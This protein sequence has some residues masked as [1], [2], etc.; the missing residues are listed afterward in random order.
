MTPK[1][2]SWGNFFTAIVLPPEMPKEY[3]DIEDNRGRR[4]V[5]DEKV[6]QSFCRDC[7]VYVPPGR[8][9]FVE[10][11]VGQVVLCRTCFEKRRRL[12]ELGI[13]SDSGASTRQH[14]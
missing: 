5:T 3:N 10:R 8:E 1:P 14:A 11:N 4:M 13:V 6:V 12:L 2:K 9:F 7:F